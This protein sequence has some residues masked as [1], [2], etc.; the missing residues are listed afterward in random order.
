MRCNYH[1]L[2]QYMTESFSVNRLVYVVIEFLWRN[3][4]A[5]PQFIF[6]I[7][8]AVAEIIFLIKTT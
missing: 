6:G 2:Q 4:A 1:S 8:V 7:L 5:V 3:S